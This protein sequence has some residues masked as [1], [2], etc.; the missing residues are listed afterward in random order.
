MSAPHS[1][2]SDMVLAAVVELSRH[3]YLELSERE[4]VERSLAALG[5]LFP[6]RLLAL[7]LLDL[8]STDAMRVYGNGGPGGPGGN[9]GPGTA[10]GANT[11]RL[12][13][14]SEP[15]TIK[16]SAVAKTGLKSAVLA[17]AR[18]RTGKRWD[19]PF[20][21]VSEGFALP[22]VVAGELYGVLDLGYPSAGAGAVVLP[23]PSSALPSPSSALPSPSSAPALVAAGEILSATLEADERAAL[24]LANALA[25]AVRN[26]HLYRDTVMLR[27]YQSRLIESAGALIMG[28]DRTWRI[29]VYNRAMSELTGF[30]REEIVGRDLRDLLSGVAGRGPLITVLTAA[31][32]GAEYS[33]VPIELP[34]RNGTPVRTVWTIAPVGR[35]ARMAGARPPVGEGLVEAV[36]MIGQDQSRVHDLQQQV[37]RAERLATIGELAAGVVH[38]LNNPLTSITVYAEYLQRKLGTQGSD[39]NDLEKLR[40]IGASAQRIL[41]FSREL[42]QYARP[43]SAEVEAADLSAVVEQSLS[44]CEHL[45]EPDEVELRRDL[46]PVPLVLAVKGQFEQVIINLLTNAVHAINGRGVIEVRVRR[47]SAAH[48]ALEIGD[49]GPGVAPADRARIFEPFFTTKPDGKGTGLGLSIVR[50]IVEQ[51]R[52]EISVGE[53]HQ[54]GALFVV[55]LPTESPERPG[56]SEPH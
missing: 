52:G 34:R 2:T 4:L 45:F 15:I 51:H 31:L 46:R 40:R 48:I 55:S 12:G 11:L 38:E 6:G 18:L 7:R 3:L 49:S 43:A 35:A 32:H 24:P 28:I 19:S 22:L 16:G 33:A 1:P 44:F 36:V 30:P 37:I 21:G 41:R 26:Q 27:D 29:A 50:N 42:V 39:P 20:S 5:Q 47:T 8:R 56:H 25:L 17:S 9:G 53:S 10:T 54:G 23:S 14:T 13:L